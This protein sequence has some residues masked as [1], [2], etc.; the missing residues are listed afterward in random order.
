MVLG[1]QRCGGLRAELSSSGCAPPA[2][3]DQL[4]NP[5]PPCWSAPWGAR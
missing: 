4:M 2:Y 5:T 3:E 1:V